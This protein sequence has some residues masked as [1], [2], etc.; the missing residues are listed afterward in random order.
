MKKSIYALVALGAL[1]R[2]G[3]P[4]RADTPK[5]SLSIRETFPCAIEEKLDTFSLSRGLEEEIL[6]TDEVNDQIEKVVALVPG[7]S[8]TGYIQECRLV[9]TQQFDST[10]VR[11]HVIVDL[12]MQGSFRQ[13]NAIKDYY[14]EIVDADSNQYIESQSIS[15]WSPTGFPTTS[16][17]YGY[18][19][20][21]TIEKLPLI[22]DNPI[23]LPPHAHHYYP[24][25]LFHRQS[26]SLNGTL[27]IYR[28]K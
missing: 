13:I 26:V 22:R 20:T 1:F 15:V 2:V 9:K 3:V 24:T 28:R 19:A 10:T 12:Y 18:N 21:L 16:L 6:I 7:V 27:D 11:L 14:L 25:V 17:K 5:K 8:N 4:A 23:T